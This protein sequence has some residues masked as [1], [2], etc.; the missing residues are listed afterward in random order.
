MEVERTNETGGGE[1]GE[2]GGLNQPTVRL[3]FVSLMCPVTRDQ[4]EIKTFTF[5]YGAQRFES[6][7]S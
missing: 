7:E 6:K 2:G 4:R 1:I 3:S 5:Y